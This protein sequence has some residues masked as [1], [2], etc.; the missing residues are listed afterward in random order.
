MFVHLALFEMGL[1]GITGSDDDT[2]LSIVFFMVIF[3]R[4]LLSRR[5][6]TMPVVQTYPDHKFRYSLS[7]YL[8]CNQNSVSGKNLFHL[9]TKSVPF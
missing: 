9:M 6:E 1:L 4:I 3:I 7:N 5:I 2:T 8:I